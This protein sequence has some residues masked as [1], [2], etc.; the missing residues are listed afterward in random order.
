MI[1]AAAL[2]SSSLHS[3]TL[4]STQIDLHDC[5]VGDEGA[6]HFSSAL[7]NSSSSS[8]LTSFGLTQ[9]GVTPTGLGYLLRS[10]EENSKITSLNLHSNFIND[11]GAADISRHLVSEMTHLKQLILNENHYIGDDGARELSLALSHNSTLEVLSLKSCG[12]GQKGAETFAAPLAQNST[13]RVLNLCGNSDIGDDGVEMIARGLRGNSGLQQLDL[14]SCGVSDEG[15]DHLAEALTAPN[16]TLTHLT[17]HKNCISDGGAISLARSLTRNSCLAV[18]V[19]SE[20]P[21]GEKGVT[22]LGQALEH[23]STITSLVLASSTGARARDQKISPLITSRIKDVERGEREHQG[24][25]TGTGGQKE[26]RKRFL[27]LSPTDRH[28]STSTLSLVEALV[29]KNR[30]LTSSKK[31]IR[32]LRE[33]VRELEQEINKS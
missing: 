14:S 11:V 10:L 24:K 30:R 3:F 23:N 20:N 31:T 27:H 6:R 1:L 7:S 12:I 22:A 5:C 19:L 29:S 25:S 18:L 26:K 21:V 15:C 28:G 32:E 8:H 9:S 2:P 16:T 4:Y 17:L 13:L 33:K